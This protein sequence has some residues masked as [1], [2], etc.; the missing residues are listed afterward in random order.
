MEIKGD[1]QELV[2]LK[3]A[4]VSPRPSRVFGDPVLAC[5]A[6]GPSSLGILLPGPRG[7]RGDDI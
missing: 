3:D 5:P 6:P 1:L 2:P 4:C 7:D